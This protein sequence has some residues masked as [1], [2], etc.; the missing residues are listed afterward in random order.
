M[1]DIGWAVQ[2]IGY[3][4]GFEIRSTA[5]PYITVTNHRGKIPCDIERVMFVE[6]LRIDDSASKVLNPD[7]TTPFPQPDESEQCPPVYKGIKMQLSSD[8]SL[9]A[10][11]E[12]TPRTTYMNT[13]NQSNSYWINGDYVV[14]GFQQGLIKLTGPHFVLDSEGMPCIIDDFDYKT[15]CEWYCIMQMMLRG[16]KHP[17]VNYQFAESRFEIH[18][19]RAENAVKV[20]SL[21]KA[22][23]FDKSWNRYARSMDFGANFYA[24]LEQQEYISR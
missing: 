2:A 11:S 1:E 12:G 14:T 16:F 5:P 3:H 17:E 6:S 10:I 19:L 13:D 21:D 23:R 9:A 22:E 20:M 8:R 18:R 7:G 4:A 24:G 15:A